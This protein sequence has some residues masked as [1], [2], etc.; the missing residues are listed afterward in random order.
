MTLKFISLLLITFSLCS[1]GEC[2]TAWPSFSFNKSKVYLEE[3]TASEPIS[4]PEGKTKPTH[5]K[6]AFISNKLWGKKIQ[7]SPIDNGSETTSETDEDSF[8]N[9]ENGNKSFKTIDNSQIDN[10]TTE[11]LLLIKEAKNAEMYGD[12]KKK[13]ANEAMAR[14]K[15][16][17]EKEVLQD[18]EIET[19]DGTISK[20]D[21]SIRPLEYSKDSAIENSRIKP[22]P[23]KAQLLANAGLVEARA[24]KKAEA[25]KK[26]QR[27]ALLKALDDQRKAE[28]KVSD[29]P[30]IDSAKQC[31]L[32]E[33]SVTCGQKSG[34][35]WNNFIKTCDV[36]CGLAKKEK[37]CHPIIGIRRN[38]SIETVLEIEGNPENKIIKWPNE[39]TNEFIIRSEQYE[40]RR[41][42]MFE[43][44]KKRCVQRDIFLG[45]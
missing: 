32:N 18:K 9:S 34:C 40:I 33:D 21:D 31:F 19:V 17:Q 8:K 11:A 29:I 14:L 15:I 6:F 10:C 2:T 16:T 25:E 3:N 43:S 20:K 44:K 42:C 22:T 12:A 23:T 38:K 24:I 28:L 41:I 1:T 39:D 7:V 27:K 36:D 4:E 37:S 13:A 45:E 35:K 26:E 30:R 5:K